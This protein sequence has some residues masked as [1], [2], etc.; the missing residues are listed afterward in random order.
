MFKHITRRR[1]S[2]QLDVRPRLLQPGRHLQFGDPCASQNGL[3]MLV[4]RNCSRWNFSYMSVTSIEGLSLRPYII[5]ATMNFLS[6]ASEFSYEVAVG[7]R[8]SLPR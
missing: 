5:G 3:G 4:H 7:R 2:W 6:R 8:H 1:G